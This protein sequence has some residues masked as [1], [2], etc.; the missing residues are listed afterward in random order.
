MLPCPHFQ[1]AHHLQVVSFV[2]PLLRGWGTVREVTANV[3]FG[4]RSRDDDHPAI[5]LV[6]PIESLYFDLDGWE[7]NGLGGNKLTEECGHVFEL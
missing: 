6:I 7:G 2:E 1:V 3:T 5:V 4:A